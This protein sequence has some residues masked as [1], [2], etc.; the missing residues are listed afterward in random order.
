METHIILEIKLKWCEW[1][2]WDSIKNDEV[3]VPSKSGVY[4]AR[5]VSGEVLTIGKSNNLCRRITRSLVKGLLPHSSGK[6]IRDKEDVNSVVI[7]WAE[8]KMPA[9]AEEYLLNQ[10]KENHDANFPKYVAQI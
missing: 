1:V 6:K 4:E 7:R 3:N 5:L 10:Y 2:N 9:A 8:T